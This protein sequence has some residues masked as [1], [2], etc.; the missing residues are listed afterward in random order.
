MPLRWL[1]IAT[2]LLGLILPAGRLAPGSPPAP[3]TSCADEC[4]CCAS[5]ECSISSPAQ[6]THPGDAPT[7]PAPDA[8]RL[9][10]RPPAIVRFMR[11]P[12][13]P[14]FAR[15]GDDW[16]TGEARTS[17]ARRQAALCIWRT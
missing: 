1:A 10:D 4:P 3:P 11:S 12:L 2:A 8:P 13:A 5:C 16:T 9:G 6:P 17:C 7:Q 14:I 15:A